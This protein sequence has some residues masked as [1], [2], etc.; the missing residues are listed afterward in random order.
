[1]VAKAEVDLLA[2]EVLLHQGGDVTQDIKLIMSGLVPHIVSW[3][4][5]SHVHPIKLVGMNKWLKVS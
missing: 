5:P 2:G 3:E 4:I 1:M